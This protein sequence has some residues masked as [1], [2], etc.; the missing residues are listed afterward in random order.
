RAGGSRRPPIHR[1]SLCPSTCGCHTCTATAFIIQHALGRGLTVDAGYVG[2]LGRQLPMSLPLNVAAP[3][4]GAAG[5]RLFRQF[6]RIS[7]ATQRG[8]G[9][10]NNY[11]A[12]Q[13]GASKRYSQGL[14]LTVAYTWSKVLSIGDDQGS[15]TNNI[16]LKANYGPTNYDRRHMLTV[17]HVYELPFGP[18]KGMLARGPA[19][20]VFGGWQLSGIFR[21]TSGTRFSATADPTPCNC[22]GNNNYAD[23]L[24]PVRLLKGA[25]PGQLWFDTSAF[26]QPGP[27]RF[28]TAGRNIIL[29]PGLVNYDVA[30]VRN[31]R[32]RELMRVEIRAEMYNLTNTPHFGN[33][34]A[35]FNAG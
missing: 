35:N 19:A 33:P 7:D 1:S 34:V 24:K 11:N 3:G 6:G 28:G 17:S 8:G 27:N 18:G 9:M 5:P 2:S 12:L 4:E 23:V 15:F 26:G 20:V 30:I 14:S 22:P 21:A 32:V 25:G 16:N 31:V 13:V 29:G 10:N